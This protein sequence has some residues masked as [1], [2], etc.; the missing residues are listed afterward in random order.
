M[1]SAQAPTGSRFALLCLTAL[2]VVFGDIGTSPLYAIRE[3]FHG[4]HALPVSSANVL[5]VLS[6]I[7][8]TLVVLVSLKYVVYVLR[9]NNRGEGGI[10]AMMALA[11]GAKV[12]PWTQRAI[13]SLGL[14]GAALLY[15]DG[16]LTPAITVL[17]AVEGFEVAT[18]VF[19]PYVVPITITILVGL[20]F[21]QSR[22]TTRVGIVFG[23]IILLWILA[24][25][26]S[27]AWNIA[28]HPSVLWALSP[29]YAV[30]FLLEN[31][32]PGYLVLGSVF[33]VATGA[34]ALYADL[35]HFSE[36][37]IRIGWFG[38]V[39]PALLLN[40]F[41]QG[42]LLLDDPSTAYNPFFRMMPAW[43]LYPSVV[44]AAA[45]ASVASQ[46]VISGVFSLTRQAVQLGYLPRTHI[47][48][49]SSQEVGQIYIPSVNWLL[50][51]AT[52]MLVVGS[53]RSTN[54]ASAYGI[55]ISVTMVITT[56]LAFIVSRQIW[57]WKLSSALAV[58]G[59]FLAADLAFLGA[60]SVKIADGG[61][62]PLTVA[63]LVVAVFITWRNGQTILTALQ[64]EGSV[65]I[66]DFVAG[67][68][69]ERIARVDGFA[70]FMSSTPGITP[71]ALLHNLK[72]NKV[73]HKQNIFVTVQTEDVPRVA[74]QER[75][76]ADSFAPD[77]HI[78][79]VRY[80][81]MEDPDVPAILGRLA[82]LGFK[83]DPMN[84]T[85]LLSYNTLM[86]SQSGRL[87]PWGFYLFSF[88]YR[89]ELRPTQ[90]FRLPYNQVI[91]IGRQIQV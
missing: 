67:V 54:L 5:G 2:G 8:W 41:G 86:P 88:L 71:S 51:V 66:Q 14:F 49:T 19:T 33:L 55:A 56:S 73:L 31:G 35:G 78:L 83:M 12:G 1:S 91:E 89:N 80:G 18:P 64:R 38:L 52:V 37:P 59:A 76:V 90:F 9:A 65:P 62:F 75:F 30:K 26:A 74:D 20:F 11:R 24:L 77:F 48:H 36:R 39:M 85:Y 4:A 17:S 72:H 13:L 43:A 46:A 50:L 16:I 3:C 42:A 60:N 61:W 44:L 68:I 32:F 34:E 10:M 70:V 87:S 47:I 6:L 29:W 15:G 81:F 27:G 82:P 22:G 63:A 79:V 28:R 7:V 45:A 40:Y 53:K 25:A 84:T 23:P 58:T 57:Q 21:F 69:T